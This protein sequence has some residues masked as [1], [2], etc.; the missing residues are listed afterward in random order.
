MF[1]DLLQRVKNLVGETGIRWSFNGKEHVKKALVIPGEVTTTRWVLDA[2]RL[3]IDTVVG[4]EF[5]RHA[6]LALVE[7]GM[8]VIEASHYGMDL[9]GMGKLKFLLSLKHPTVDFILFEEPASGRC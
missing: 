7:L 6:R 8:N 3:K 2:V 9:P 5:S 1:N 4:G